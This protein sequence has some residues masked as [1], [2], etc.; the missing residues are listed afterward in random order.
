MNLP[1]LIHP[2]LGV[3]VPILSPVLP[4]K[5]DRTQKF[6]RVK[7]VDGELSIS[8]RILH[9]RKHSTPWE[10][11][12]DYDHIPDSRSEGRKILTDETKRLASLHPQWWNHCHAETTIRVH[13]AQSQEPTSR[14]WG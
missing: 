9:R 6:V 8:R 5:N 10:I 3:G 14:E 13:P 11:S 2:C 4:L 7:S 12:L 1:Q